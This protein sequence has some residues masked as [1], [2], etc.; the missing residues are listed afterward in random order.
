MIVSNLHIGITLR[1]RVEPKPLSVTDSKEN[2]MLS[3]N[4]L[5]TTSNPHLGSM[6]KTTIFENDKF[7]GY[8]QSSGRN[9]AAQK[10]ATSSPLLNH[11]VR[12]SEEEGCQQVL[13]RR[14]SEI[15]DSI[16]CSKPLISPVFSYQSAPFCKESDTY[17][18]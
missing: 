10:T 16:P 5:A 15:W 7:N 4:Y 17:I 3:S 14:Y 2:T 13:L 6:G 8:Q 18:I 9:R 1:G 11:S 12:S